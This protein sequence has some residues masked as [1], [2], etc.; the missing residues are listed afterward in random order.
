MAAYYT[1]DRNGRRRL[2]NDSVA[3]EVY[4]LHFEQPYWTN[5]RHYVGYTTI[6]AENRIEKHRTGKGS[7]LVNYA[8]N[9]KGIDFSIG[10]VEHFATRLLA[11]WR[12]R[13]L[14]KE[15][16]LSRHCKICQERGQ[17]GN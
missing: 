2:V 10:L 16:H 8:Y 11:R 6:G 3:S 4:I 13:Q 9:K 5:A 14:K 1:E 17:N 12:E 15:G 7:L